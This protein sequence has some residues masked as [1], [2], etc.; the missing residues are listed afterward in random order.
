MQLKK[1]WS[2]GG[3]RAGSAP[4]KS[5]T[6]KH[7][8]LLL[9]HVSVCYVDINFTLDANYPQW[10]LNQGPLCTRTSEK[11]VLST[12]FVFFPSF[13]FTDQWIVFANTT[14]VDNKAFS[15]LKFKLCSLLAFCCDWRVIWRSTL[16][17]TNSTNSK[18]Q[19][20]NEDFPKWVCLNSK[21]NFEKSWYS[22]ACNAEKSVKK[23]TFS[24]DLETSSGAGLILSTL[25]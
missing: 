16:S 11:Y 3:A 14:K 23:V 1:F 5:A 20:S 21:M 8:L 12:F 18:Q 17:S 7:I 19:N 2:V 13:K 4:P 24:E 25:M 6:D 15:V 22:K 10:G 9:Y